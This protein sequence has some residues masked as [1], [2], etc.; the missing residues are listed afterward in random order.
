[1]WPETTTPLLVA[2]NDGYRNG[3]ADERRRDS[4]S[5]L[6]DGCIATTEGKLRGATSVDDCSTA[7]EGA[8]GLMFTA[9]PPPPP[10][11][12]PAD[13]DG[14]SDRAIEAPEVRWNG[15]KPATGTAKFVVVMAEGE[16]DGDGA[17]E[18]RA[19]GDHEDS[20]VLVLRLSPPPPFVAV[21]LSE[22]KGLL[23]GIGDDV[24]LNAGEYGSSSGLTRSSLRNRAAR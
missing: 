4:S 11:L 8:I 6:N 9:P 7:C 2:G 22:R 17:R 13:G 5:G 23:D 10:S 20:V 1:V 24:P 15:G 16:G 14:D 18:E 21:G 12:R 3:D 19:L